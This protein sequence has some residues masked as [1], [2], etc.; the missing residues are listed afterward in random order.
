[1][2]EWPVIYSEEKK[3]L[4]E[5]FKSW[6]IPSAEDMAVIKSRPDWT[7]ADERAWGFGGM[8]LEFDPWSPRVNFNRNLLDR[9]LI[10]AIVKRNE[11][12]T[13][14][15]EA[16]K[17]WKRIVDLCLNKF[18]MACLNLM[19]SRNF[20]RL[21]AL[22]YVHEGHDWYQ[23]AMN[24]TVELLTIQLPDDQNRVKIVRELITKI[25]FTFGLVRAEM[26]RMR[27][28]R[29]FMNRLNSVFKDDSKLL[30]VK[31]LVPLR[32]SKSNFF[33]QKDKDF[34]AESRKQ[35]E[36]I[37]IRVTDPNKI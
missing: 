22:L 14:D 36:K 6:P 25:H 33:A 19:Y 20:T 3:Y 29:Q 15:W 12:I 11:I 27:P 37:T 18:A 1:M 10:Q 9:L 23:S 8:R 31:T 28:C 7:F 32:L 2:S 26:L 24:T 4:V 34:R 21:Q 35:Q 17:T 13:D 30:R 5:M 16:N